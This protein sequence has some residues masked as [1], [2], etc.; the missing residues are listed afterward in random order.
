MDEILPNRLNPGDVIE[1]RQG[2]RFTVG[3][4]SRRDEYGEPLYWLRG[5]FGVRN[6]IPRSRDEL[7]EFGC[8]I[9]K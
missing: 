8:R 2:N 4:C 1:T 6:R 9:V 7:Q 5:C 3:R